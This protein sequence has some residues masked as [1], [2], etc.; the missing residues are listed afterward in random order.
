MSG[1]G[2]LTLR[3]ETPLLTSKL[4][5]FRFP[6]FLKFDNLLVWKIPSDPRARVRFEIQE[7]DPIH[8][9]P[10]TVFEIDFLF[11]LKIWPHRRPHVRLKFRNGTHPPHGFWNWHF[12]RFE[13]SVSPETPS[14]SLWNSGIGKLATINQHPPVHHPLDGWM[15]GWMDA[16]YNSVADQPQLELIFD[17]TLVT[18]S[19]RNRS[20]IYR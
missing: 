13:N 15:D 10:Q 12:V 4:R 18:N 11:V 7:W 16:C 20:H 9:P 17:F 1:P 8:P 19:V 2:D 14:C 3:R 6:W 5:I